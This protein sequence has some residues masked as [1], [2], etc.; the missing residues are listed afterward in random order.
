MHLTLG[1]L[2]VIDKEWT[3]VWAILVIRKDALESSDVDFPL[4]IDA[5][6]TS[7]NA[8]EKPLPLVGD[9]QRVLKYNLKNLN[10]SIL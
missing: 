10:K 4:C 8:E 1:K 2:S 5:V 7:Q 9:T 6:L 3:K